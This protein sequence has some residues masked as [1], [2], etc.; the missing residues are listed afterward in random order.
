[1]PF[2]NEPIMKY[3][4]SDVWSLVEPF[5]Y[6]TKDGKKITVPRGFT[7]DLASVPRLPIVWLLFGG[8][9]D[10]AAILHDYL[11]RTG[12]VSRKE[13]DRIFRE[14]ALEEGEGALTAWFM[15]LGVRLFGGK[16]YR[17][18]KRQGRFDS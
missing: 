14:A 17:D 16:Y 10:K 6:L 7:T 2:L 15:W 18:K 11:Y 13:A 12:R 5:Q 3:C 9:A 1:M 4:G 8:Q